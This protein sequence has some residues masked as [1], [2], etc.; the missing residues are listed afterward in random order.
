MFVIKVGLAYRIR[1]NNDGYDNSHPS[2]YS[3]NIR[4]GDRI[5]LERPGDNIFVGDLEFLN[6]RPPPVWVFAH[7]ANSQLQERVY[8]RAPHAESLVACLRHFHNYNNPSVLTYSC[9]IILENRIVLRANLQ[10]RNIP[11]ELTKPRIFIRVPE[12]SNT[13][14]AGI[15]ERVESNLPRRF[16]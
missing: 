13:V 1:G 11:V 5:F 15:L 3:Y 16:Y 7:S 4:Q 14:Y 10:S 9:F 8:V 6:G 2:A 12:Q